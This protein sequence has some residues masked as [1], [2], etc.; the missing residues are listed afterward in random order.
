MTHR[1]FSRLEQFVELAYAGDVYQE[2]AQNGLALLTYRVKSRRAG[3]DHLRAERLITDLVVNG[4]SE[5]V[6]RTR[7]STGT[8]F[9]TR[10]RH[11]DPAF[12]TTVAKDQI[13]TLI[14]VP[15]SQHSRTG[16]LVHH[17][18]ITASRFG[19]TTDHQVSA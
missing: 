12:L 2:E 18:R 9:N 17:S 6:Y 13:V 4:D 10:D 8:L 1:R 11:G 16:F 5:Y 15:E 3:R 19:S 14:E 7:T